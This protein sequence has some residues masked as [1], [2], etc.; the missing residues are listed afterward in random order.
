MG[1]FP[2]GGKCAKSVVKLKAFVKNRG[3]FRNT[4]F[5]NYCSDTIGAFGFG[6]FQLEKGLADFCVENV[7]SDI[8]NFE[9]GIDVVGT[10]GCSGWSW[11]QRLA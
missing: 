8:V 11:R 3:K 9:G 2:R 4:G 7:M 10:L 5:Y 1:L 6:V